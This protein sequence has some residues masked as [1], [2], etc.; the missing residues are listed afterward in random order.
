MTTSEAPRPPWELWHPREISGTRSVGFQR[1]PMVFSL[2]L[3]PRLGSPVLFGQRPNSIQQCGHTLTR[4]CR[5]R[6]PAQSKILWRDPPVLSFQVEVRQDLF[7]LAR[8]QW[9]VNAARLSAHAA[10]AVQD[11]PLGRRDPPLVF[12]DF[13]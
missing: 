4:H 12:V 7:G 10:R 9:D 1:S 2:C 11:P 5:T 3:V 6:A 8:L 13:R